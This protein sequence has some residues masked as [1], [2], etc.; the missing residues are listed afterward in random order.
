MLQ[1]PR[2]FIGIDE[3]MASDWSQRSDV[4]AKGGSNSLVR[5]RRQLTSTSSSISGLQ[6]VCRPNRPSGSPP[7]KTV[8]R[9]Q[10]SKPAP[11]QRIK[12]GPLEA[13]SINSERL[14]PHIRQHHK[15]ASSE[16]MWESV[17]NQPSY[18]PH[19]GRGNNCTTRSIQNTLTLLRHQQADLD[20]RGLDR[21]WPP[22]ANL[23]E[24]AI[25][26]TH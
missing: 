21:S 13:L 6:S 18:T 2:I 11:K 15:G 3:L 17:P 23:T 25:N 9:Y 26:C 1:P 16:S 4:K 22:E 14:R 10:C 12:S 24:Q 7:I 20:V 5:R 8:Q 19:A